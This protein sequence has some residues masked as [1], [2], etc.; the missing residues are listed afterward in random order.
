MPGDH[1]LRHRNLIP[2]RS[3]RQV[4]AGIAVTRASDG[5]LYEPHLDSLSGT[6]RSDNQ[7]TAV[8]Q[9]HPIPLWPQLLRGVE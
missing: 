3:G 8:S 2:G 5:R 6:G 7:S 4:D 9:G 1:H